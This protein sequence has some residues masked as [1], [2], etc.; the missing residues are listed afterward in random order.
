ME[1]G[2]LIVFVFPSYPK[3]Q[4]I[5]KTMLRYMKSYEN[6]QQ[7]TLFLMSQKMMKEG[8]KDIWVDPL[9]SLQ[10]F[11]IHE[12]FSCPYALLLH[13]QLIFWINQMFI[14]EDGNPTN[15]QV[16]S[17]SLIVVNRFGVQAEMAVISALLLKANVKTLWWDAPNCHK[18][19]QQ[20]FTQ[21]LAGKNRCIRKL[22]LYRWHFFH[23]NFF[24]MMNKCQSENMTFKKIRNWRRKRK[25]NVQK[26]KKIISNLM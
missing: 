1:I 22:T 6:R 11:Y 13:H 12:S 5:E 9:G 19:L 23:H 21:C 4:F 8:G 25:C 17:D 7:K 14:I 10:F 24:F 3:A 2:F 15:H 20:V 26:Q 18:W 16:L